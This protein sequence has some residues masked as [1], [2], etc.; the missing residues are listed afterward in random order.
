ME[1]HATTA[2]LRRGGRGETTK[3]TGE[4]IRAL[5]SVH[6]LYSLL[7]QVQGD[8]RLCQNSSCSSLVLVATSSDGS[9]NDF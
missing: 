7:H 2:L 1:K 5:R 3:T 8:H 4:R 9:K 6:S